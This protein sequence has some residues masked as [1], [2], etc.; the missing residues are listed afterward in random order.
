VRHKIIAVLLLLTGAAPA[1]A[2]VRVMDKPRVLD[3][4]VKFGVVQSLTACVRGQAFLIT[5]G[6]TP[7]T[8]EGVSNAMTLSAVQIYEERDGRT[9]P[10][11]CK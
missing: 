4:A 11:R 5:Y 1:C 3:D 2:E 6:Q 10:M 7:I 8:K 9:V